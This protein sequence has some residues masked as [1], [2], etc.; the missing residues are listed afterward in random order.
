MGEFANPEKQ[1]FLMLANR[2][3]FKP[4]EATLTFTDDKLIVGRMDKPTGKWEPLKV[5][6][7]DGKATVNVPLEEGG[8]ELLRVMEK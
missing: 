3:A 2:D 5:E 8:G 6:A 4:H 1:R 7:R